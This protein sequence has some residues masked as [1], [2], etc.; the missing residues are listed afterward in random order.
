HTR[1]AL[2]F[3]DADIAVQYAAG[4]DEPLTVE[5]LTPALDPEGFSAPAVEPS[6]PP[7]ADE[8]GQPTLPDVQTLTDI[9]RARSD[10]F[11]PAG[12]TAGAE[13]VTRLGDAG[14]SPAGSLTL[15]PSDTVRGETGARATA[16]DAD[17]LVYDA[18]VSRALH[19]ASTSDM[20]VD[21]DAA[22]A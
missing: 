11:W 17:L 16:G 6:P 10:V 21:R 4:L 14:A 9:G 18:D 13:L 7:T 15:V 22:L 5:D 8:S 3:G 1:F 2:Q 20:I 19:A 12:G